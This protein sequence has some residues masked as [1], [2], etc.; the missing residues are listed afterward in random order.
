MYVGKIIANSTKTAS[1]I[2]SL[3]IWFY[4]FGSYDNTDTSIYIYHVY[5]MYVMCNI[6]YIYYIIFC[7]IIYLV[8][9][10]LY[11]VYNDIYIYVIY[12][13]LNTVWYITEAISPSCQ[14]KAN[15]TAEERSSILAR[16]PGHCYKKAWPQPKNI[17]EN[18]D[19]T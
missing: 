9:A 19:L 13:Q 2:Q 8:L 11:I 17:G 14:V 4:L 3:E 18:G 15:L 1:S 10:L 12:I 16:F 5:I 7:F 6:I